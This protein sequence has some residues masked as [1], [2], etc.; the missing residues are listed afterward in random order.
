MP[1]TD[2]LGL[3]QHA[4]EPVYEFK[5]LRSASVQKTLNPLADI[6]L[7]FLPFE[8]QEDA[9]RK[10]KSFRHRNDRIETWHFLASFNVPPKV[11][12][13]VPALCGLFETESGIP[14]ESANAFGELGAMSQCL[15]CHTIT[16]PRTSL[17]SR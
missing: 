8:G 11:G 3:D 6:P 9:W 1:E 5:L 17:H 7:V 2:R 15:C 13:Y 14:S 10:T 16:S 4:G 12:G